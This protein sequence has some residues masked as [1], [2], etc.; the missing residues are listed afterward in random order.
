LNFSVI[1]SPARN[2]EPV[3]ISRSARNDKSADYARA[4]Y[5]TTNFEINEFKTLVSTTN[6][7]INEFKAKKSLEF[8]IFIATENPAIFPHNSIVHG[9]GLF[10]YCSA[11]FPHNSI[12]HGLGLFV[13]CESTHNI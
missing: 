12:V 4:E 10:V 8:Y 2:I 6:F 7:E 9:L 3:K 1:L 13:Y 5:S 11:I